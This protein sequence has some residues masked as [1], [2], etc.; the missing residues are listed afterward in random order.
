VIALVAC[1][2]AEAPFTSPPPAEFSHLD[3]ALGEG[4]PA[5]RGARLSVHYTGWLYD[6]S[7]PDNKGRQ[8]DSSVGGDPFTFS[9][10][11][12]EVI[13]GWDRGFEG[14]RVGGKRRLIIPPDL[15]YGSTGVPGAGIPANAG[16]VFEME[17]MDVR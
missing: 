17:L 10:G 9:L 11:A 16:L 5:R 3:L 13:P 8:F 4:A 12:G 7:R 6:S 2:G 1:G 15:G 14:M